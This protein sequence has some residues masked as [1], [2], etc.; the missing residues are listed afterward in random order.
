MDMDREARPINGRDLAEEGCMEP[1]SQA[2]N[3]GE[4]GLMVEGGSRLKES[5]DLL[6]TEDGGETACD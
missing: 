1:E 6:H 2:I 5:L 4:G 3:G